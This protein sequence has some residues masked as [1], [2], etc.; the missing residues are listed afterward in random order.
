MPIDAV[1]INGQL[2][3]VLARLVACQ[4][5]ISIEITSYKVNN[6]TAPAEIICKNLPLF[7]QMHGTQLTREQRLQCFSILKFVPSLMT[8]ESTK[9]WKLLDND[10]EM[11]TSFLSLKVNIANENGNEFLTKFALFP[12]REVKAG[13]KFTS[14]HEFLTTPPSELINLTAYLGKGEKAFESAE[15]LRQDSRSTGE[16]TYFLVKEFPDLYKDP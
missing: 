12:F 15:A 8:F 5:Q 16:L 6:S 3:E 10:L 7:M 2:L 14:M 1:P 4:D 13:N 11:I 9:L